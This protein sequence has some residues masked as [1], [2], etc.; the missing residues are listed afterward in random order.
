MKRVRFPVVVER[1]SSTVKI[2]RDRKAEGTYYRV[3]YYTRTTVGNKEV[4][5]RHRLNFSDLQEAKNEAE[6]KAAWLSRLDGD[7][8]RFSGHDRH[9]YA[10][11]LDA[12]KQFGLPLDAIAREYS[13]A[14]KLLDGVP[15]TDAVRFYTRHHGK[16]IKPKSVAAAVNEM[17]DKKTLK[18]VSDVYI[19]DLRYRLGFFA[20]SFHCDVNQIAPDDVASFFE[21]LRL[22]SRSHNNFLRA[23]RTFFKFAQ[24]HDWLSKEAD[25]L[26]RI[27]KR[28]EK[29]TPADIFTPAQ[30]AA[31]LRNASPEV[32]PCLALAA[33][34]GLRSAEILRGN[35]S[36]IDTRPGFIEVA[37]R[38]AKTAARRIVPI[39]ENLLRWLAIAPRNGARV[40]PHTKDSFFK[41]MRRAADDA[42]IKWKQNALR[43]S[44]VTY[45]LAEIQD[46]N[47]VALEAGNSPQMIF[48]HYRELATPDQGRNWFAIAPEAAAKVVPITVACG[49]KASYANT[50][51]EGEGMAQCDTDQSPVTHQPSGNFTA[52]KRR[53]RVRNGIGGGHPAIA[54]P[55]K[56]EGCSYVPCCW[57]LRAPRRIS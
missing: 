27:E 29:R 40:W 51:A 37:A 30:V 11:A 21:R 54:R 42:K 52:K 38:K 7:A 44:F 19:R 12:L 6:A 45:R 1:G 33:F 16:G 18:G 47:R 22:S 49:V 53:P 43:H 36:D 8:L 56:Q 57:M 24:K 41:A 28:N 23:L 26:S 32:A 34:A 25:L 46:V 4:S 5:E 10:T 3:I 15:L 17:I 14:R 13:E 35:W 39:S 20:Q 2:Y 9:I 55:N 48:R 31:L 50:H